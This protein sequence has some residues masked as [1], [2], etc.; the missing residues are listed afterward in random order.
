M[1][2]EELFK[3]L[4]FLAGKPALKNAV[5]TRASSRPS[6]T[7]TEDELCR[8]AILRVGT[9]EQFGPSSQAMLLAKSLYPQVRDALLLAGSWTWAMKSTTVV[10]TLPRPEYK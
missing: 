7:L 1:K 4:Q 5:E 9:A 6:S 8:Q 3:E 2:T 10:E